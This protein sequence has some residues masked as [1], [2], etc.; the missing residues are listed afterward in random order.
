MNISILLV[1]LITTTIFMIIHA[2]PK[3]ELILLQRT[4]IA[5]SKKLH[6]EINHYNSINIPIVNRNLVIFHINEVTQEKDSVDI[7]YNNL[8]IFISSIKQHTKNSKQNAFY[9][10]NIAGG[11]TSNFLKY[12]PIEQN[13]VAYVD[14]PRRCGEKDTPIKTILQLGSQVYNNFTSVIISSDRSRGPMYYT[15][16]GEWIEKFRYLLDGNNVGIV[17]ASMSCE[18]FPHVQPHMYIFRTE[19]LNT[20][21]KQYNIEKKTNNMNI[22]QYFHDGISVLAVR[23][24]YKLASMLYY[25]RK[26]ELYF[27]DQCLTTTSSSTSTTA[28]TSTSSSHTNPLTWCDLTPEEV[29]FVKWGGVP[30]RPPT[31]LCIHHLNKVLQQTT[32]LALNDPT[33]QLHLPETFHRGIMYEL[34]KQYNMEIWRNSYIASLVVYKNTTTSSGSSS[35][36]SSNK[37][38]STTTSTTA[39]YASA[40]V[41]PNIYMTDIYSIHNP[42]VCFLV[43]VETKQDSTPMSKAGSIFETIDV[44]QLIYCK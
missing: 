20:A 19:L 10:F 5:M 12:L 38:D 6:K 29:V 36:D 24:G 15:K 9:I 27:Q 11:L 33:L 7:S 1:L 2:N 13:N 21:I 37:K 22:I 28:T 43:T 3:E 39:S 34:R 14:W 17:G 44:Q 18:L 30:L 32:T 8:Q 42:K 40:L 23:L 4:F 16:N 41:N 31:T 26:Q 35:N 25:I